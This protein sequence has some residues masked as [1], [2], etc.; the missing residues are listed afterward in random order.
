MSPLIAAVFVSF[1]SLFPLNLSA[2]EGQTAAIEKV[3]ERVLHNRKPDAIVAA[4]VKGLYEVRYGAEI[5]YVT[6]DGRFLLQGD[7]FDL[8]S[9]SNLTEAKRSVVRKE[10]IAAI[11][12]ATMIIFKPQ[13]TR[14]VVDV[15]TDVDCPYC[16]KMHKKID[17]YLHEG[18]EVRY[19]AYPRSGVNT[20]SYFKAV[21]VWCSPDRQAAMTL[22]KSG[23]KLEPKSCSNPVLDHMAKAGAIGISGTPTLVLPDGSVIAGYIPADQLR[24]IL[25]ERIGQHQG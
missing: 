16:R 15:F 8:Q 10:I 11:D 20:P 18:I 13:K 14:Y 9:I 4:P 12:P 2:A 7:L 25:D 24:R 19:L 5:V 22:A 23:G 3:L 17:R 6:Q 21:A 1:L